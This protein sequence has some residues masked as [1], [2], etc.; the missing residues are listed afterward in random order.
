MP[1]KVI[2]SCVHQWSIDLSAMKDMVPEKWRDR[3]SIKSKIQDPISGTVMPALPW[4]HAYWNEDAPGYE[5]DDPEHYTNSER[6]RS[7]E[8]ID[9]DLA[10]R[11]VE[12]A[13]LLGHQVKFINAHPNPEYAG[14]LAS[15]YNRLLKER[16]LEGSDRLT[17]GVLVVPNNPD[18]AVEE[19]ERYADDPD[20]VTVS[21]F[22]GSLLPLGHETVHP[23]FEA[24]E[25]AD[26]PVT[27]HSS[28]NPTHRQT[29]GG[30]PQHYATFDANLAQ[31]HMVNFLS[32]VFRGVF[33]D[34]PD[35]DVVWAGE[36]V[37]WTLHPAWRA[38][39]YYRNL[40]AVSPDLEKEPVDYMKH[41]YVTTYP[42]GGLPD[43][44]EAR[45]IEMVGYDNVIWGSGYPHW[46]D[47]EVA[48][49]P[50]LPDGAQEKVLY[51][52]ARSVYG[53]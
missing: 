44:Q 7:P 13:I 41:C 26:M 32:M 51:E 43:E 5:R 14:A 40:R 45:L 35:L 18:A 20:M 19:I 10:E 28:G 21:L 39:R 17:G 46:N 8:A 42:L 15:A 22:G 36:G 29:A 53:L 52:N 47:D 3:L 12:T 30:R 2:D 31:N 33:D 9:L 48:D 38:T 4:Y 25:R 27:I 1:G 6:Y 24:A 37:A 23:I 49:L 11:D 50:S 16:W 34:Y